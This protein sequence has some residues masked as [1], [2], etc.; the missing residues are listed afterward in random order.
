M[1]PLLPPCCR[2]PHRLR[3]TLNLTLTIIALVLI[4]LLCAGIPLG[5]RGIWR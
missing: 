3:D 2:C 5:L 1:I 4:S